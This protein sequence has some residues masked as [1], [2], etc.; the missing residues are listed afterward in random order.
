MCYFVDKIQEIGQI[1]KFQSTSKS[2]AKCQRTWWTRWHC[3]N[4]PSICASVWAI[5]SSRAWSIW[6][7]RSGTHTRLISVNGKDISTW[8]ARQNIK[9][10]AGLRIYPDTELFLL[11][12]KGL[13]YQFQWR[14]QWSIPELRCQSR[15]AYAT[16]ISLFSSKCVTC[17]ANQVH[18]KNRCMYP[19]C[20][21][22]CALIRLQKPR[23]TNKT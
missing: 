18:N 12:T 23:K 20:A 8:T 5:R 10:Q 1:S 21:K 17:Y 2:S 4:P 6:N 16:H 7:R 3:S 11:H 13:T 9:T 15:V 19:V 22:R 14:C